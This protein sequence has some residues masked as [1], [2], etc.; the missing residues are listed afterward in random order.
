MVLV[1]RIQLLHR[2]GC[3]LECK[4]EGY[5]KPRFTIGIEDDVT[6]LSLETEG[7]LDSAPAGTTA[8][9]FWGLGSDGTVGANKNSI[10]IIGDHTPMYAQAYFRLRLKEIWRCNSFSPAFR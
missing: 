5:I 8:C 9:K 1:L 3:L 2:S 10:K 4:L 6:N 7:K